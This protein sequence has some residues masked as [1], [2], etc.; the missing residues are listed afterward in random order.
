[1]LSACRSN[2]CLSTVAMLIS[3]SGASASARQLDLESRQDPPPPS[4]VMSSGPASSSSSSGGA[5]S[6]SLSVL[7]PIAAILGGFILLALLVGPSAGLSVLPADSQWTLRTRIG[8]VFGRTPSTTPTNR[9]QDLSSLT[10]E[11]LA[12]STRS[13]AGTST[14]ASTQ[15]G[16]TTTGAGARL[17]ATTAPGRRTSGARRGRRAVRRTESGATVRTLPAYSKEA[18]DEEMI[19]V[20]RRSGSGSGSDS[21]MS[22]VYEEPL[23][24][25]PPRS[26]SPTSHRPGPDSPPSQ[27]EQEVQVA[28]HPDGSP[29][30]DGTSPPPTAPITGSHRTP[31][32]VSRLSRRGWGEAPTYLEA[33]SSPSY[34]LADQSAA[35]Q[36][37]I[38][39]PRSAASDTF[40]NATS[41]FSRLLSRAGFAPGAFR[42]QPTERGR[43][44]Q[45]RRGS[46]ASQTSL[47]L[48]PHTSRLS[49]ASG[50]AGSP[51]GSPWAS[52]H[53]LLI[54]SPLPHSAV[55]ASFDSTRLPRAGLSDDQM[56]FLSS[57]EAVNL[58]GV[59]LE[60][61]PVRKPRRRSEAASVLTM[62]LGPS[63][64]RL[65]EDE[66]ENTPAP[67]SWHELDG[68][69]RRTEAF[70]R[71]NLGE[72]ARH[73]TSDTTT[74]READEIRPEQIQLPTS[75]DS[76]SV[77]SPT[78]KE[79]RT[80]ALSLSLLQPSDAPT[81][82]VEP[83]TPVSAGAGGMDTTVRE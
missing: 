76:D 73:D 63:T 22:E 14:T 4:P 30:R 35:E 48:Q 62:G 17:G 53:S 36:G 6:V 61:P 21:G 70:E 47:L 37:A 27:A 1:M 32:N 59:R 68:E 26:P 18:G 81:L 50:R 43:E 42:Q 49:T 67:P 51:E 79:A 44:M 33:M 19:L 41:G 74:N 57:S 83:P 56:R 28:S 78:T 40:R 55:R 9:S 25:T 75:P 52:T 69:R 66:G 64:P 80:H 20:R 29:R 45:Q 77:T 23:E 7:I 3:M 46:Y 2:T 82:E 31:S 12:S 72:P 13:R 24:G 10:A 34:P 15:T 60:D 38:P 5:G 16:G 71:R 58:A 11:E 54:S 65:S 39:P 8:R